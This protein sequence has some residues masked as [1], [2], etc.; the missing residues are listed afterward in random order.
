MLEYLDS[1]KLEKVVIFKVKEIEN[2]KNKWLKN[3]N[4][5][6]SKLWLILTFMM[7][8]ERWMA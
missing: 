2:M 3:N 4:T 8:Y 5:N 6:A 7:W 1:S